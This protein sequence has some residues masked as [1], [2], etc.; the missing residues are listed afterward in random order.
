MVGGHSVLSHAPSLRGLSSVGAEMLCFQ[1]P[2]VTWAL[3]VIQEKV[4]PGK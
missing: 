3:L 2:L 1:E 4:A